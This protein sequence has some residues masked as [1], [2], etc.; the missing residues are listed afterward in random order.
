M[1]E[2]QPVDATPEA[3]AP[4]NPFDPAVATDPQPHYRRLREECPV[5]RIDFGIGGGGTVIITDYANVHR[6]LRTPEMFSSSMEAVPI[7]QDRPLIPLQLDPPEHAKYRRLLDPEFS[8]A[9][10]ASLEGETRALVN[11]LVDGFADAGR[12]DF[13]A[14]LATPLPSTIFLR[15]MGLSAGDTE[16]FLRWRDNII[17]PDVPPG[18]IEAAERVRDET[19]QAMYAYFEQAIDARLEQRDDGL[20]S[21]LIDAEVEGV[22]LTREEILDITYL[23][24]LGG[25]DT[26]TA[27]LDCAIAYLAR[28]PE[29][30]RALVDDPALVPSAVEELLRWES[31]VVGVPRVVKKDC[32]FGGVDLHAG[33]HVM[34]IVG[35]ANTDERELD[36]AGTVDLAR[37]P[38][39]HL[40]FGG[41]PHRCL[42]S[43]LARME[44]RVALEEF[45]RRIPEYE[46]EP[47]A[48]I[49]FSP[50]IRQA[51]HLPLVFGS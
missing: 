35:S 16:M 28:H 38:N 27:T 37:T 18:D 40:A 42:G 13:H 25:L 6:A 30:R 24:M 44:L 19:G 4:L 1:T 20:F 34:V 17:R 29:H 48:E 47:G 10:A 5:G 45:H 51:H 12:C 32:T 39:R 23:L 2:E 33:E 8:P 43:H 21:R 11:S 9:C 46:I 50:G 3:P 14:E 41:G 31:P 26:V 36:D 7:G 15:L 22:R 49:A